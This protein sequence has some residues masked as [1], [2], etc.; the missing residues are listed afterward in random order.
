MLD[1]KT[2]SCPNKLV[3]LF[4][5]LLVNLKH[6]ERVRMNPHQFLNT[7]DKSSDIQVS[8]KL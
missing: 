4:L 7:N 5:G 2:S 8:S 6:S 3:S 1:L